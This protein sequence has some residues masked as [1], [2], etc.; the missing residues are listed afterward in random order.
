M[1]KR[2]ESD[3]PYYRLFHLSL[4]SAELGI[5]MS[6]EDLPLQEQTQE[7]PKVLAPEMLGPGCSVRG[8][9]W[10]GKVGLM[11]GGLRNS[12][13]APMGLAAL[14][15]TFLLGKLGVSS[16]TVLNQNKTSSVRVQSQEDAEAN[17]SFGQSAIFFPNIILLISCRPSVV[18]SVSMWE[19]IF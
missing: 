5:F 4:S 15:S 17:Y 10:Q 16:K 3:S 11:K 2:T 14:F 6:T 19:D 9:C 1:Q 12:R 13:C 7:Q 8:C 18:G